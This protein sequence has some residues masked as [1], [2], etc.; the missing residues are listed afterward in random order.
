VPVEQN[1]SIFIQYE[2]HNIEQYPLSKKRTKENLNKYYFV[3]KAGS[4]KITTTSSSTNK[5]T[6]TKS[7]RNSHIISNEIIFIIL[8]YNIY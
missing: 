2:S 4:Q 5:T 1:K 8:Y 6:T 7:S 3:F